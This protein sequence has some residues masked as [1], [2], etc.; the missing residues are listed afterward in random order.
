MN[1]VLRAPG[2]LATPAR[3][4]RTMISEKSTMR[5]DRLSGSP[6][7]LTLRAAPGPAVIGSEAM[8]VGHLDSP[9]DIEICGHV[10]GDVTG[11]TI[12]VRPGGVVE[13]SIIG[14]TVVVEGTVNGPLTALAVT[15][16]AG[17]RAFGKITHHK[18]TIAPGALT[19]GLQPWQPAQFFTG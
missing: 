14:D 8:V 9:G 13:G 5:P 19:Q 18:L 17:G 16:H 6:R 1:L 10:R 12:V 7:T 15:I 3:N 11:R 2:L 4:G